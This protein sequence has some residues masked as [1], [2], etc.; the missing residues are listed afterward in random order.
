MEMVQQCFMISSDSLDQQF[1]SVYRMGAELC[2]SGAPVDASMS[3]AGAT[4]LHMCMGG[5]C[6]NKDCEV[7]Y[8]SSIHSLA[9]LS[10]Q[11]DSVCGIGG[12]CSMGCAALNHLPCR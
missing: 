5:L 2:G 6:C 1:N 9:E 12:A 8:R 10:N 11:F 4:A 7:V 3:S